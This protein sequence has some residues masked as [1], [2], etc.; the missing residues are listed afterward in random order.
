MLSYVTV[1]F[2]IILWQD[3]WYATVQVLIFMQNMSPSD[4]K[5]V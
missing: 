5:S 2:S 3:T 4:K 1:D